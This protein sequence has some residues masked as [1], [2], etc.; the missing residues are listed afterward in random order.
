MINKM[1]ILMFSIV[2]ILF[3]SD[4]L[5]MKNIDTSNIYHFKSVNDHGTL[6]RII[7]NHMITIYDTCGKYTNLDIINDSLI[8]TGDLQLDRAAK[9]F[10]DYFFKSYLKPENL[11]KIA[12][13]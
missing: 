10:F 12:N 6:I 9:I 2:F 3:S 11:R 1:L 4:S 8:V 13:D 5:M 7:P